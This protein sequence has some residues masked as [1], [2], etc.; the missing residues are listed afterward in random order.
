MIKVRVAATS[1]N[2]GVGYDCLGVALNEYANISFEKIESGLIFEGIDKKYQN[3]DNAIYL[4]FR[5]TLALLKQEISGIKIIVNTDIPYARGLGSSAICIVAGIC[6][7]NS[8][9]GSPLNKYDIFQ[10]ASE[11]EGHPDNVAPAIFGN[12]CAAFKEDDKFAMMMFNVHKN[13]KFL[14]I[15]PDH[16]ISTEKARNVLPSTITYAQ[17]TN[18]MGKC[19]CF[20]KALEENNK[21]IL[22]KANNDLL[23]EPYRKKLIPSYEIIK[24]ICLSND[25]ITFVIS[26]SGSTMLAI[27]DQDTNVAKIMSDINNKY[28]CFICKEVCASN[29]GVKV[30]NIV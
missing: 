25:A 12:L 2:M 30:E 22:K 19:L 17:A 28:P 10:I 18:Q 14:A 21:P 7:A 6:G 1:A 8:L 13:I 20:A 24:S 29:E 27:C 11:L 23:H 15:I 16:C 26:G 4:A 3:I 9:C 5:Y